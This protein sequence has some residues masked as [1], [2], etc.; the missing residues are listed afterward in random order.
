MSLPELT[1]TTSPDRVELPGSRGEHFLQ[2]ALETSDRAT[3]FY[4]DQVLDH[5]NPAM[6]EF[7]G[8]MEMA[9]ISTADADGEC[10]SSLRAGS[11]GFIRVV[12]SRTLVYPEYRGNGVMAS[13]GNIMENPH[14]GM[15]MV[16][17]A[18]DLIGLHVNGRARIAPLEEFASE[19]EETGPGVKKVERWVVVEVREAYVHCR[20]HIPRMVPVDRVRHWGTD[21]VKRKGGDFF[22]VK[23]DKMSD[24]GG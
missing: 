16:D 15:L 2:C 8:R 17:F 13:L 14:V 24:A 9:F 10:D 3:R 11:A 21:D 23:A 12:D 18:E 22:G 20:K 6:A 5:L 7:V 19:D 4:S 1:E